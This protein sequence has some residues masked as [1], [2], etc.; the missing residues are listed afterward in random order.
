MAGIGRMARRGEATDANAWRMRA[1]ASI[2]F[3]GLVPA[4]RWVPVPPAATA[5]IPWPH[6]AAHA[7]LLAGLLG[8]HTWCYARWRSHAPG[9]ILANELLARLWFAVYGAIVV[10]R[11]S[12]DGLGFLLVGVPWAA[13]TWEVHRQDV[14]KRGYDASWNLANWGLF[15]MGLVLL[16]ALAVWL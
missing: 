2:A 10:G 9:R 6:A 14:R 7:F 4:L 13:L 1:L 15:L 8:A 12:P 16:E 11:A 3:A 5:P